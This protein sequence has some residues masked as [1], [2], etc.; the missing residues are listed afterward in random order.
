M[1]QVLQNKF[2]RSSAFV[3]M[4]LTL[5]LFS[6]VAKGQTTPTPFDLSTGSWTFT[7]WSSTAAANNF[8]GNGATGSDNTTG[9]VA[10]ASANMIF[11]TLTSTDP[12][13]TD[14]AIGN[15]SVAYSFTSKTRIAGQGT[16]G[17]SFCNTGSANTGGPSGHLG[18]AVV[19]LKTTGRSNI[20]VK[21][22]AGTI[23]KQ[24][25]QFYRLRAQYRVGSTGSY[26]DLPN[27]SSTQIE[28]LGSTTTNNTT[29]LQFGPITLPPSCENQAVVQVRWIYYDLSGGSGANQEIYLDDIT[30]GS[31]GTPAVNV[32]ANG[33]AAGT[34]APGTNNF[35]LQQY[36]LG[37]T[38]AAANITS[39]NVTTTG[40]YA[41]ADITNLKC[42][43][44]SA[45]PFVAGTSTLLATYTTP[46][47]A[48]SKTFPS[49]TTQLLPVG[50]NYIYV[51]AD[52]ASGATLGSTIGIGS[53]SLSNFTFGYS[54]V[55]GT[56]PAAAAGTQT[57]TTAPPTQF[58]VT[59]IS[60]ASPYVANSFSVT[61]QSQN[62]SGIASGVLANTAFTLSTNGSAGS[63]GGVITGTITAGSNSA[64]VS[65]VTLSSAGTGATIT[66]TRNSGDALTAG[67]SAPFAVLAL[68]GL[69]ITNTSP[70]SIGVGQGRTSV[71]LQTYNMAVTNNP[72]IL[73]G[74]TVTTGGTYAT[75]D[76]TNLKCWYS[77]S[78]TFSA[79]TSTL[80]ATYT[81][82]ATAGAQVFPSF[83]SQSIPVGTGYIYITADVAATV[84]AGNTI[85]IAAT[86]FANFNI[87]AGSNTGTDPVPAANV[88]TLNAVSDPTP[89][90]LS[91]GS[92]TFT[93]FSSTTAA[94]SYPANGA[95]GA[96]ATTGIATAAS[97][98]MIFHG[99]TNADPALTD[100]ATTDYAAAYSF[101]SKTRISGQATHGVS[102]CNT[103]SANTGGPTGTIGEAVLALKTTN[104]SNITVGWT[105]GTIVHQTTNDYRLRAQYRVGTSGSFID[106]PNTSVSQ[107][108]YT[109]S[110]TSDNVTTTFSPITLPPACENQA[111]VQVRWVYY[112]NGS[113][114]GARQEINLD[115]ITVSSSAVPSIAITNTSPSAGTP[116]PGTTNVVLQQYNLAV[117]TATANL[118]GLTVTTGGTYN[119]SDISNLKCWYNTASSFTT[120]TPTLLA[121]YTSPGT[122]GVKVF[123][124]FTAQ[125]IPVGTGYI[126]I[127]ADLASGATL[128]KTINIA[129][130]ALANFGFS[131]G[132]A[133]GTDPVP[134]SNSQTFSAAPPTQ[135]A[136]TSISPATPLA[137]TTFSVTVQSQDGTGTASPV[138]SN[139][140]FTLTTNGSAG[141]IGGVITG[142]ITA[143]SNSAVVSGVTLSTAGTG[144]TVTATRTSG[145]ALTAG[146]SGTFTVSALPNV[147]ISN[148]SPLALN[149]GQGT[150]NV[151]L[152]TYNLAV[153]TAPVTISGLTI[154]TGGTYTSGDLTDIKCWYS[155]SATFAVGTSTLLS[156]YSAPGG[157][158]SITLPSFTAQS[159]PV[160]TAYIYI[161]A[162]VTPTITVTSPAHTINIGSTAFSNFSFSASTTSGTNPVAAANSITINIIS[163]PAPFA[164]STGNWSLTGW[165]TAVPALS[166]PANGATGSDATTGVASSAA[167]ANMV[168]HTM[169]VSGVDPDLT[170]TAAHD[171]TAVYSGTSGSRITASNTSGWYWVNTSTGTN[172]GEAVLALNTTGRSNIQV[173]WVAETYSVAA[174]RGYNIRGQYR[175]GNSGAYNDLPNTAITQIEYQSGTSTPINDRQNFGAITLPPACEN[176]PVVQVRWVYYYAG[177]GANT[178][179]GVGIDDISVT[180][181]VAP[182]IAVSGTSPA[183]G[184][185]GPGHSN[186]VLQQY[187]LAVT[188][189]AANLEGVTITTAGTYSSSDIT[190]LKCWYSTSS[191]FNAG[192]ATLLSTITT[193]LGAG[194]QV[195]PSFTLQSIAAA[196][197]GYIF[198]TTDIASGATLGNTINIGSTAFANFTF[199]AGTLTGT[200]PVAASNTQTFTAAP[201]TQLVITSITPSP[202]YA[203]TPG[204]TVVVQ[205]QDGTGSASPVVA[206]TGFTLSTNGNAGTIG[207][208]TTGSIT[209]GT[210]TYTVT[211]V[212]LSSAGTG[213]T[214]TATRTSG[215]ALS[216]GT[217]SSFNVLTLPVVNITNTSPVSTNVGLS[218]LNVVLQTY[219]L[220]V[221]NNPVVLSGLTVT[222]AGSYV[223]GDISNLKCWYSA[224]STFSAGTAT[225]VATKTT[226]LDPG[227]QVFPSFTATTLP[228]GT[229]YIYI[230]A[231]IASSVTATP[232]HT[233]NIGTTA[234]SN[235]SLSLCS[236]TGTN[237]VAAANAMTIQNVSDPLPFDLSTG[238]Y[239]FTTWDPASAA[240]TYPANMFFHF[241]D[242]PDP[243]LTSNPLNDY[244]IA[245]NI[246]GA[247]H[248]E[249]LNANGFSMQ[250]RNGCGPDPTGQD[251]DPIPFLRTL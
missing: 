164:L 14:A 175:I 78:S 223:A 156:T 138:L 237:P 114:T 64:T 163:D 96:D 17:V 112:R 165:N 239:S 25:S 195:F 171:Y 174:T 46:G 160:G 221:T 56:D 230:T 48:G 184:T 19:A 194:T 23:T 238:N 235:I 218:R 93:G 85:N 147:A 109:G 12:T 157:A 209:A 20:T 41:S 13:L 100:A 204:F 215:D 83:T 15:Y 104:R 54:S 102:F 181:S 168:F 58:V 52:V 65:G 77:A 113:A 131:S 136:I 158:G 179:A 121:T 231:D 51:T 28:Y 126:Y 177:S 32:S 79:G 198:I 214:I 55:S 210:N 8:P 242:T 103:G 129:T 247:T 245:Y 118:T 10:P 132:T 226:S 193:G 170:N 206:T 196:S 72:L 94:G 243:T 148:T 75:T 219:D 173:S 120:G 43:Y 69:S 251:E 140:A 123:P 38:T 130:N 37:V 92:W 228:V 241:M 86:A 66:A 40:T 26:I 144:V 135:L 149:V 248:I 101:T 45:T 134:A 154:S 199:S 182:T 225:L 24:T 50:S 151:I 116:G 133:T 207:G 189:S 21:W 244:V 152:Q 34:T 42:W 4:L 108:E 18:E 183:T 6:G 67:T 36:S 7:G 186:I 39:L 201:P 139:T 137:T 5:Q 117:T 76:I 141:T 106:L 187:N 236:T 227:T 27:T 111:I 128:G 105:A 57:I 161:T 115:D 197:T 84:T 212:T 95:T 44:S 3:A 2:A 91:T 216:A 88:I 53:N 180:S 127:T 125:S 205:S 155:S 166:Y 107:I 60:P 232:G 71:I 49:F 98:N 224:S 1:K 31:S 143:G 159:L 22:F 110:Q 89:F 249:G 192:T 47:T 73:N 82:P 29:P 185:P 240:G 99:L 190:S 74:L 233:I 142:T 30:I 122:A 213:A 119:A 178:R 81:A 234:F 146:T 191:T 70:A 250:N 35:V 59:S 162:D 97:A 169:N 211:G 61:V 11:H 188:T 172:M 145:D 229:A 176:Q 63:I 124:S 203:G 9:V 222:S 62:G 16:G 167:T 246:G 90:D 217:S 153:T 150:N 202:A 68:P 33:P 87:A 208:T 220:A 200:D 80:L